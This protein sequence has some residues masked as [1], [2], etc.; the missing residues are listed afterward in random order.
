MDGIVEWNGGI[1]GN[2][3]A[4]RARCDDLYPL[5]M[6]QY[7]QDIEVLESLTGGNRGWMRN[8]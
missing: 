6:R 2:D 1:V 4:H 5:Y 7:N 8:N 3:H